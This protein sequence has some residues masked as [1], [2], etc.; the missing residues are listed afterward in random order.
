MIASG[1]GAG[2]AD[3]VE[4][5][6]AAAA[7][8]VATADG[9]TDAL[10]AGAVLDAPLSHAADVTKRPTIAAIHARMRQGLSQGRYNRP[11]LM[12]SSFTPV[13]STIGGALLGIAASTLLLANGH[14][15]G[16]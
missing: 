9:S 14:V 13:S 12:T 10:P 15:C 6:L 8:A 1:G 16:I 4:V 3:A 5:A 7:D 2:A 11:P